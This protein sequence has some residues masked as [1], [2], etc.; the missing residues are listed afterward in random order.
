[1]NR[2]WYFLLT[3]Q[4]L[5]AAEAKDLGLV[6]EV[7]ARQALMPRARELAQSIAQ[8]PP[9]SVRY[10]RQLLTQRLKRLVDEALPLGPAAEGPSAIAT[11]RSE[12]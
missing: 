12:T 7:L 4:K 10:A 3:Q 2:G 5:T 6:N 11:F 1:M 8:Q 9:L